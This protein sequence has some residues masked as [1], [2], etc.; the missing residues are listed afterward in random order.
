MGSV[1]SPCASPV[2]GSNIEPGFY[3]AIGSGK[4]AI[5]SVGIE[6]QHRPVWPI[7]GNIRPLLFA[8]RPYP[9]LARLA[10]GGMGSHR[11]DD[12]LRNNSGGIIGG[13][14]NQEIAWS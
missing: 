2:S 1:S 11:T 12:I 7:R 8:R 3:L 14:E 4:Q 10:F 6:R 13:L 5:A 9:H